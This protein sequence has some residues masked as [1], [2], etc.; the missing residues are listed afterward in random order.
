MIVFY[1]VITKWLAACWS[2]Q[3]HTKKK[4]RDKSL[5][6]RSITSIPQEQKWIMISKYD[7]YFY[8]FCNS[9]KTF[10]KVSPVLW[11]SKLTKSLTNI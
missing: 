3:F 1:L 8:T 11:R 2:L 9:L 5:V 4:N 7:K 6:I 10:P